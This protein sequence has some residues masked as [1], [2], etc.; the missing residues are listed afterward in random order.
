MSLL[1][2]CRALHYKIGCKI[3]INLLLEENNMA[4]L[5]T[6]NVLISLYYNILVLLQLCG[7]G[8]V[9]CGLIQHITSHCLLSHISSPAHYVTAALTARAH[10]H[11]RRSY[12]FLYK[13]A[14]KSI[15][16]CTSLR[17]DHTLSCCKFRTTSTKVM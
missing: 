8:Y 5:T 10:N 12:L 13:V 2:Y 9:I 4:V 14:Y 16:P 11:R 1:K 17:Q 6:A 3:R 7:T 15:T